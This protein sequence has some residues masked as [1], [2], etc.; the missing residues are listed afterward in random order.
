MSRLITCNMVRQ[1]EI[2]GLPPGSCLGKL[3][4]MV[5]ARMRI[6]AFLSMNVLNS[7]TTGSNISSSGDGRPISNWPSQSVARVS[8]VLC[9]RVISMTD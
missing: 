4:N 8:G 5:D 1:F 6:L 3:S 7:S 9:A 2:C